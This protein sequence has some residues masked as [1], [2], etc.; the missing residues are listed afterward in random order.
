MKNARLQKK[1]RRERYRERMVENHKKL[2]EKIE[3]RA[4]EKQYKEHVPVIEKDRL[5]EQI[6]YY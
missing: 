1:N 6:T 5:T 3:N 4:R 2:V